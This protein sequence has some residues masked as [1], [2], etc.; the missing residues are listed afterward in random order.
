MCVCLCVGTERL[1]GNLRREVFTVCAMDLSYAQWG[2]WRVDWSTLLTLD[3][4]TRAFVCVCVCV[5]R[6]MKHPP[7][8]L[9]L[10]NVR[11]FENSESRK[12]LINAL[13]ERVTTH[14]HTHAHKHGQVRNTI[15]PLYRTRFR[16]TWEGFLNLWSQQITIGAHIQTQTP[17]RNSSNS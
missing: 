7:L 14:M 15:V 12:V 1:I 5:Y 6:E 16:I 10:E 13:E 17:Q 3:T 9:F 2:T 4:C 8:S 11:G